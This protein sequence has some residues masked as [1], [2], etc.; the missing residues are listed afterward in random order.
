M[1]SGSKILKMTTVVQ[2]IGPISTRTLYAE[3]KTFLESM[4]EC[5]E[6]LDKARKDPGISK[7]DVLD[8]MEARMS[9]L[10]GKMA[11]SPTCMPFRIFPEPSEAA[12]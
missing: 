12:L 7:N 9:F 4:L 8:S 1:H 10:I 6:F 2:G 5:S 11:A 3:P